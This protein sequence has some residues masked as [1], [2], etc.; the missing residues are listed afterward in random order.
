MTPIVLLIPASTLLTHAVTES[1]TGFV[2]L[3]VS[4]CY[5]WLA[6]LLF[7]GTMV[8]HDYS[9]TKNIGTT[10]GTI[11]GMVVIMFL[12]ALFSNLLIKMMSFISNLI[13]EIQFRM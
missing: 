6:L 7:F 11:L 2:S 10:L 13:S 9:M 5:V 12:C 8:T 3:L 4:V 1:E